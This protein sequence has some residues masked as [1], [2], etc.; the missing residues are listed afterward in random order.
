MPLRPDAARQ[1]AEHLSAAGPG[2][3]WTGVTLASAWG[4]RNVLDVSL[5]RPDLVAEV[6]ADRAVDQGVFRHPLRFQRI[7]LDVTADDVPPFGQGLAAAAG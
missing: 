5:V 6:S 1:V 4:S 7:R 2:H 3:P